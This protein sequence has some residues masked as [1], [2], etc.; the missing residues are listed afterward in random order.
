MPGLRVLV[1]YQTGRS[2]L[3]E[4]VQQ[5]SAGSV[6][7]ATTELPRAGGWW[8]TWDWESRGEARAMAPGWHL[9]SPAVD[10]VRSLS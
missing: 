4:T 3:H 8:T 10:V 6:W 1:L 5:S 7:A 9:L 2:G